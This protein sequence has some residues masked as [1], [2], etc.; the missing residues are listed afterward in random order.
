MIGAWLN[1]AVYQETVSDR[2]AP[3]RCGSTGTVFASQGS[4]AVLSTT[5]FLSVID[6]SLSSPAKRVPVPLALAPPFPLGAEVLA[7][8]ACPA[9]ALCDKGGVNYE[10]HDA[11]RA[12]LSGTCRE[13]GVSGIKAR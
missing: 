13:T 10:P 2:A 8:Q 11:P 12:S 7:S 6:H 9:K 3:L 5:I 4:H 1:R